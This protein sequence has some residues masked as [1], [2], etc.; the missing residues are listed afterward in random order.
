[1]NTAMIRSTR[2]VAASNPWTT[3]LDTGGKRPLKTATAI[4]RPTSAATAKTRTEIHIAVT[5]F[6]YKRSLVY[7][8]YSLYASTANPRESGSAADAKIKDSHAKR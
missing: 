7:Y 8:S 1:M 2:P 3:A 6:I 5:S 4:V